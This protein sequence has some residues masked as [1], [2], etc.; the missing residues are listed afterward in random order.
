MFRAKDRIVETCRLEMIIE[1][2]S[3]AAGTFMELN[4]LLS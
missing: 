2:F 3:V 4:F 1:K